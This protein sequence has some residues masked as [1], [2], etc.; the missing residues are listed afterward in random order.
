MKS[1]YSLEHDR[2]VKSDFCDFSLSADVN[3]L[4][5]PCET[6][7]DPVSGVLADAPA[8]G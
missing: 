6:T 7:C 3:D 2:R 8:E 1:L 4:G 5:V